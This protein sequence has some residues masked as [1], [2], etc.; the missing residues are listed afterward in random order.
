MSRKPESGGLAQGLKILGVLGGTG[1]F[2]AVVIGICIFLGSMADEWLG[3]EY[4]GK[5]TGILLG[6]PIAFYLI[7]K[8][9]KEII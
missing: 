1:I 4:A 3:L 6:F 7:W 2:F 8:Q 5:L 9:L